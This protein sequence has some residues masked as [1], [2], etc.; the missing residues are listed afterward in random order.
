MKD[1]LICMKMREKVKLINHD[2]LPFLVLSNV[3]LYLMLA[4][5][6]LFAALYNAVCLHNAVFH[7]FLLLIFQMLFVV[8][9]VLIY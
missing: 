5:L 7:F 3:I 6:V 8:I 4:F 9:L 2:C 1:A